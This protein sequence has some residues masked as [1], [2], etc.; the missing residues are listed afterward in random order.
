M[1]FNKAARK[2]CKIKLGIQGPSGS[3]KTFSS[4][5]LAYGLTKNWDKI[6]VIDSENGS[7]NL[8]SHLGGYSV[9]SLEPPYTPEMYTQAIQEAV[10]EGFECVIVDSLSHE[11]DGT[12]GVLEI[13][14]NMQG[15]SFTNWKNVTPRHNQLIQF[16][17]QADVHLIATM[18]SKQDYVLSEKSGKMVPEK[19]GLKSVQRDGIDYEFTIVFELNQRHIATVSKDRTSLFNKRPELTLS[20]SVGEEIYK[21]CN[22]EDNDILFTIPPAVEAEPVDKFLGEIFACKNV[23]EL[24]RLYHANPAKQEQYRND[25]IDQRNTLTNFVKPIL[26]G[27]HT[28]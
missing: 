11:W 12:G 4:L 5:H 7:A 19:V 27:H 8:Y 10:N 1:K 6:A 22:E 20:P 26:N 25:F 24:S 16:M 17:L 21:W 14:G 23:T 3:G 9:L 13:H 28:V 18:R 2:K 15:N